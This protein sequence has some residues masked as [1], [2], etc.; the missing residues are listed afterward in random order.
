MASRDIDSQ[1]LFYIVKTRRMV[2][3]C[4]NSRSLTSGQQSCPDHCSQGSGDPGQEGRRVAGM[5]PG[6]RWPVVPPLSRPAQLGLVFLLGASG[7]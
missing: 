2:S 3:T 1:S 7:G 5:S 4:H 6:R